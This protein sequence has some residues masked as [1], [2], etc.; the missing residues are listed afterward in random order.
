[1]K[2][3]LQYYEFVILRR[4]KKLIVGGGFM[5]GMRIGY[6]SASLLPGSL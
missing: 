5:D 2:G 1:M 6:E 4:K 3:M